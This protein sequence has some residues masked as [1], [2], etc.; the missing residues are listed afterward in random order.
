MSM[1]CKFPRD[2]AVYSQPILRPR[3]LEIQMMQLHQRDEIGDRR[4]GIINAQIQ[5]AIVVAALAAIRPRD[6]HRR[7]LLAA[8]VS[9]GVLASPQ[10][11]PQ[12]IRQ[13]AIRPPEARSHRFDDRFA[14]NRLPC[15]LKPS[16][17]R[18]PAHSWHSAPVCAAAAPRASTSALVA[19]RAHRR[20][21]Q[22][23]QGI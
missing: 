20:A 19:A 1:V 6:Q 2:I 13:L 21:Q 12:P 7:R 18:C 22:A 17:V 11:R 23:A 3:R 10:R 16:P 8:F 9:A 15:T 4:R 14:D 5:I